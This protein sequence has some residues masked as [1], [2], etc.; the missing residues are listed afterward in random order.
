MITPM[1]DIE[2]VILVCSKSVAERP[3]YWSLV[4]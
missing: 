3:E 2:L 1:S 4:G